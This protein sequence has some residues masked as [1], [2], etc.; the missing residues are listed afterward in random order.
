MK[1]AELLAHPSCPSGARPR[2]LALSASAIPVVLVLA[3]AASAGA[4]GSQWLRALGTLTAVA[5]LAF[6]AL[7]WLAR[8][9]AAA[10]SPLR[11]VAR[12]PLSPRAAVALLEVDGTRYLIAFGDSYTQLLSSPAPPTREAGGAP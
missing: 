9:Q 1:F 11:V 3:L 10:T 6:A 7:R 8:G 4:M 5:A 12:A 2:R